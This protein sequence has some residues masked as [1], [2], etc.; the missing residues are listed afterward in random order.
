METQG[1]ISAVGSVLALVLVVLF[2]IWLL[3][4]LYY[5]NN[6]EQTEKVFLILRKPRQKNNKGKCPC[7]GHDSKSCKCH[8]KR[9]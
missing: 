7:G 6:N 2:I 1:V 5:M 8:H 4:S 9:Y 3:Y